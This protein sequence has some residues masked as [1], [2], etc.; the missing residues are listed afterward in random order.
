MSSSFGNFFMKAIINSPF[1]S[2]L[3]ES[4]AVITFEGRK[5]GKHYS[6]PVN[7]AHVDGTWTVI[8]MRERT[9]WR[10]LRGGR[11]AQL[12]VSGQR[13]QVRGE[14]VEDSTE[15]LAGLTNYFSQYPGF[16]RY[17]NIHPGSDGQPD[18]EELERAAGGR[19][20]IRL[21]PDTTT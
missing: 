16:T 10:N 17:F 21:R 5:S 19:V 2:L 4:F 13:L 18:K 1:H 8:S 12:R 15:V 3:G 6:T 7:V 14:V 20:L 9:W 11:K